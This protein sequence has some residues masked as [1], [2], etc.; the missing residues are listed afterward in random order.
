MA[1]KTT[2]YGWTKPEAN[3]WLDVGVISEVFEKI[4][5]QMK[6]FEGGYLPLTGGTLEHDLRVGGGY[7]EYQSSNE[8]AIIGAVKTIG[9]TVGRRWL[10]LWNES[11][12][13]RFS[14]QFGDSQGGSF[15]VFGSHN[16][17][18]GSYT[19]NGSATKRTV[20]LTG[21]GNGLL[22]MSSQGTVI[23]TNAGSILVHALG[24]TVSSLSSSE[25]NYYAGTLTIESTDERVNKAGV[26]Y[27][28]QVL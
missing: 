22:I 21:L 1:G 14:L 19:G 15:N 25:L 10:A 9:S 27:W 24:G 3:D 23:V 28:Y 5:K 16:K 4:D 11:R 18:S 2:N 6:A 20:S 8:G 17:T 13:T 7:A 12:E 26:T